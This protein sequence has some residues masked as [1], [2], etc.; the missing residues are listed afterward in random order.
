MSRTYF[1]SFSFLYALPYAIYT[2]NSS[3]QL[4][5]LLRVGEKIC[6]IHMIDFNVKRTTLGLV[7]ILFFSSF[8][9]SSFSR[10][11]YLLSFGY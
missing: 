9:F 7:T 10:F 3:E 1:C 11:S 2:N 5:H 6:F 8:L 4:H